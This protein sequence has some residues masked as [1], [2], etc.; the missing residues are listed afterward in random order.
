MVL[1]AEPAPLVAAGHPH[2]GASA[3]VGTAASLGT[4]QKAWDHAHKDQQGQLAHIAQADVEQPGLLLATCN[5]DDGSGEAAPVGEL[6]IQEALQ[7]QVFLNEE[8]VIPVA[9][10][11]DCWYL[12]TGP[13]IT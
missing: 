11:D 9:T 4:G 3:I 13:A 7:Q 1:A 6:V 2:Q 12:D 8:R 10:N 5:I